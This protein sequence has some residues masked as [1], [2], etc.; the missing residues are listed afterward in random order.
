MFYVI[1]F[2]NLREKVQFLCNAQPRDDNVMER[3]SLKRK[4][5]KKQKKRKRIQRG[6]SEIKIFKNLVKN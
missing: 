5:K 1:V 3:F 2:N 6:T 4:K